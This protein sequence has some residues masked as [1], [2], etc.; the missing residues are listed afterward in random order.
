MFKISIK[1]IAQHPFFNATASQC[2]TFQNNLNK[3][4]P[5]YGSNP[6]HFEKN[7]SNGIGL[8]NC[9]RSKGNLKYKIYTKLGK[10]IY[11]VASNR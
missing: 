11:G 1:E 10:D 7:K 3:N 9:P 8:L 5:W 4:C 6:N 2:K